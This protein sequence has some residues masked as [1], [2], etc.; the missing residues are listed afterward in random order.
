[1]K[2]IKIVFYSHTVDFGGTWCS[3]ERIIEN[4]DKNVFEPYVLYN[5]NADNNRLDVVKNILG[6][7]YVIPFETSSGKLG[8]EVGYPFVETN[9][10]KVINNISPDIIHFARSGYF[11]WPFNQRLCPIQI[12]TNIF[13]KMILHF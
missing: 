12:E 8:P 3:H 9:F 7:K 5:V 6:E 11:E 2:K 13:A 4:I 1:M 10:N